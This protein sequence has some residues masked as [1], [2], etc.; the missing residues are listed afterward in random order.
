MSL[1]IFANSNTFFI[2]QDT[3]TNY[4][5]EGS[6]KTY[7]SCVSASRIVSVISKYLLRFLT[8]HRSLSALW[9]Y[10]TLL[11]KLELTY[12]SER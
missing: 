7:K 12:E 6:L 10:H 9:L 4:F 5:L 11:P 1:F 3:G 2:H 8:I